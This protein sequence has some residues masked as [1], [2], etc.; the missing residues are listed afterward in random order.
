MS[1]NKAKDAEKRGAKGSGSVRQ[2]PDGR[3]EA[4]CT[5]NG[6]QRSFYAD[7]QADALKAMRE[8]QKEKDDGTYCDPK[9]MTFGEWLD[10]WLEEYSKPKIKI[11]SYLSRKWRIENHIKPTLGNIQ[12]QKLDTTHIQKL[13]NR[14]YE[15]GVAASSVHLVNATINTALTQAV[16]LR[17]IARNVAEPCVLPKKE[18]T[19]IKPLTQEQIIK[20]L[21]AISD[22]PLKNLFTV[23]LF[24]GM[25]LS[26]V[27]GLSWDTVDFQKDEITIRQQLYPRRPAKYPSEINPSTKSGK[28]RTIKPAKFVM[29]ILREVNR[30]QFQNR[31]EVGAAWKNEHNLVFVRKDGHRLYQDRV[32]KAFK[33]VANTIQ[34]PD[35]RFHDLRHT[36]A[37]M[38][39]Q[40]GDDPKTVQNNLGHATAAFTLDVYAHVTED[41]TKKSAE[42]M[43]LYYDE[44]KRNA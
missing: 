32:E 33:E 2:R 9:R 10:I 37:V 11:N 36:Y 4:R 40:A 39:L 44:L 22:H 23:T 14:L 24:T 34:R 35:A 31:L 20:F 29:D 19:E 43:Q 15:R 30:E 6:K 16:K 18:K 42:R 17:Y 13:Y 27:L 12:L 7:K 41:M 8:A 28:P 21:E 25:R 1:N 38:S 5:I 3:W 26:E